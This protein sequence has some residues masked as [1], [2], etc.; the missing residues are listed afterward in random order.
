M[1]M[2]ESLLSRREAPTQIRGTP[3]LSNRPGNHAQIPG[4]LWQ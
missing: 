2:Q 3:D 1:E 4:V